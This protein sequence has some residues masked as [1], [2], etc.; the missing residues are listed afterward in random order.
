MLARP[1]LV[2]VAVAIVAGGVLVAALTGP[3]DARV[4]AKKRCHMVTKK[5]RG[6]SRRVVRVCA[7][8]PKRK[9]PAPTPTADLVVAAV[10]PLQVVAGDEVVYRVTVLNR[11]PRVARNVTVSIET[12][13]TV[14]TTQAALSSTQAASCDPPGTGPSAFRCRLPQLPVGGRWT[15]EFAGTASVAGQIRFAA[16]A[17]SSTSDPTT[18]NAAVQVVTTVEP[19][20]PSHLELPPPPL[21]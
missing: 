15:L 19:A 1:R 18:R 17:R 16:A 11:G 8:A 9:P 12:P 5:V 6:K 20:P 14:K 7:E 2:A 21:S 4:G 10:A 3:S 13:I